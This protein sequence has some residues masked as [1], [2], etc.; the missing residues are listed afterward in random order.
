[1]DSGQTESVIRINHLEKMYK[2]YDRPMDRL[3]ESLGLTKKKLY[4]EHYALRDISFEVRQGE[5][6]GIIGTNGAGKS[7]ILKI[8][9]GVLS[10]TSG[11]VTVNGRISALLELGA[12][13]NGE[14]T[15][16][17]N[18]YL[19]GTMLG[20]S[21]EEIDAKLDEILK[22][23]DIGEFVHQP[24]KTYSSG[25]F[26]RLA[27]AVAINIEPE[28]LI[29]DEALSVGD[30]FFQSKCFHKFEEFKKLGKTILFVSHD[31]S[32]ISKYCDRAIL[33][34]KG[35]KL[36]EGTP[37]EIIG[38]YKK[39]LV[40][41]YDG[42][43]EE[44]KKAKA[45]GNE[46]QGRESKSS[47][48]TSK[49]N[50]VPKEGQSGQ[51]PEADRASQSSVGNSS[52]L[53]TAESRKLLTQPEKAALPE[54]E[55]LPDRYQLSDKEIWKEK[56][57]LNPQLDE[58]GSGKA[59]IVDFAIIDCEGNITN[60]IE[61]GSEFAIRMKAEFYE[62]LQE[63]VLAV[64]IKNLQGT[65]ITGT[66]T[67]FEKKSTGCP[68]KG[69]TR[70][71]TFVQKMSLQGGE[72]LISFG[73]TGFHEADFTVYHRLYDACSL[74]VVSDKNTVGFYDMDSRVFV[75]KQS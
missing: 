67:M 58:Y 66:N 48:G 38:I 69:E 55:A 34:D 29:V 50:G 26:V 9:T 41:Q 32:S 11:E 54:E 39:V 45:L 65:D 17:E 25:M 3:K 57:S 15:G 68:K 27:F 63:P 64:T 60:T 33:L 52:A 70:C 14:Y 1:M 36:A 74:T 28:I 43:K 37:Q 4:K 47:A 22:F 19:N 61:K 21:K 51:P 18:V 2:L 24:V 42:E 30:V 62:E 7:T 31:L 53:D 40:N 71:V 46:S 59:K 12:G 72:Y 73:C 35:R 5:T 75:E 20:F 16:I 10:P 56:L 8:I 49:Q 6:V 23:A 13:F 44:E